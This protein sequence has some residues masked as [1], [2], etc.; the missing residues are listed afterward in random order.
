MEGVWV[1][2]GGKGIP[3]RRLGSMSGSMSPGRR[4]SRE[5][6]S[7]PSGDASPGRI[8]RSMPGSM[9]PGRRGSREF[10]LTSRSSRASRESAYRRSGSLEFAPQLNSVGLLGFAHL[11][12]ALTRL[13][14]VRLSS[15]R[16]ADFDPGSRQRDPTIS[17]RAAEAAFAV[18]FGGIDYFVSH[19]WSDD[20][21]QK[22]RTLRTVARRFTSRHGREPVF[23]I[24]AWCI[25]Q[26]DISASVRYVPI[27][28]M[29]SQA[30]L[31]LLGRTY[32]ERAWCCWELYMLIGAQPHDDPAAA[33]APQH[34]T[35]IE[36]HTL[37]DFA[38][39]SA[40]SFEACA[41]Y[42]PDDKWRMLEIIESGAGGVAEFDCA[43]RHFVEVQLSEL[44]HARARRSFDFDL[45]G[46]GVLRKVQRM[47]SLNSGLGAVVPLPPGAAPGEEGGD[48][49][50]KAAGP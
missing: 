40:F 18:P 35:R 9:S 36:V 44:E 50:Q 41:C 48:E 7:S 11:Q 46:A 5:L 29:A 26:S 38:G 43:V 15:V 10:A 27:F 20:V 2:G 25:D 49:E 33:A 24:D 42:D 21:S 22:V 4:G 17:R 32:L 39:A 37:A 1:A 23:W 3:G 28:L 47:G 12:Q 30:C 31:V 16:D 19:S 6:A 45:R 14:G 13:R 8:L 34:N